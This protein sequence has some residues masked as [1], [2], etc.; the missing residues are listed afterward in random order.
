[1][2]ELGFK[3]EF[4]SRA[5]VLMTFNLSLFTLLTSVNIVKEEALSPSVFPPGPT[6]ARFSSHSP[7]VGKLCRGSSPLAL[8]PSTLS[9]PHKQVGL[10]RE[11]TWAKFYQLVS[12]AGDGCSSVLLSQFQQ[13]LSS[14]PFPGPC[15]SIMSSSIS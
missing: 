11:Q 12:K 3:R 6:E 14:P 7:S 5:W 8:C 2:V 9:S 4:D 15:F 1:M 10:E 13:A